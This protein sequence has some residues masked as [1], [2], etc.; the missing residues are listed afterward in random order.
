LNFGAG[1]FSTPLC[2]AVYNFNI[3]NFNMIWPW[4]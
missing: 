4:R 1:D 3:H 2:Q